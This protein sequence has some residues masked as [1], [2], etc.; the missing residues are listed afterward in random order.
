MG[1]TAALV[2]CREM[3]LKKGDPPLNI[4]PGQRI[5]YG[6]GEHQFG[7]LRIPKVAGP[8]SVLVVIHGGFWQAGFDLKHLDPFCS[9]LTEAGWA[10]WSIEYRR[11][12]NEGGGWPG[13]IHDV[14]AATDKL[15]ELAGAHSLDLNKVVV[16][17]HSAGGHLA[18]WVAGRKRIPA[19][20]AVYSKS[21]LPLKGA[22][23]LAGV[24]DLKRAWQQRLGGGVVNDLIGGSP[25]QF[26]D[27]YEAASPYELLPLGVPQTL[28]HGQDDVGVPVAMSQD[29]VQRASRFGDTARLV[30]LPGTGHFELIQPQ[31][32]VWSRVLESVESL[33]AL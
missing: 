8:H 27:R 6:A 30:E 21:P 9:A 14:A 26:P 31:S 29:Y 3:S 7:E 28:V 20:S 25:E 15:R 18:P 10:T 2:G 23:S 32:R 16:I 13:T 19:E 12:G 17:G 11:I 33:F 22:V 4:E 5:S 1:G 24:C